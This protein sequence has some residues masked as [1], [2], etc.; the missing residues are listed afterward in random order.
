MP[1]LAILTTDEIN[2]FDKP[3]KFTKVQREKYFHINEKLSALLKILRDPI[4][5]LYVTPK[6]YA[7]IAKESLARDSNLS[8]TVQDCLNEYFKIRNE[9]ELQKLADQIRIMQ[10]QLQQLQNMLDTALLTLLQQLPLSSNTINQVTFARTKKIH[11]KWR[12]EI[13]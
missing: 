7:F 2:A 3:P 12:Q 11:E 10:Q 5:K 1:R 13:P 4:Y 8:Q 9:I 6:D